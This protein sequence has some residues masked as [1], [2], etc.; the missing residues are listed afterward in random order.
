MSLEI[1]QLSVIIQIPEEGGEQ[2]KIKAMLYS[3]MSSPTKPTT[4]IFAP[5]ELNATP[6]GS[7]SCAATEKE[8]TNIA[9]DTSNGVESVYSLTSSPE[10]PTTNIFTPS[11]LNATPVDKS[12]CA[13][14]EKESTKVV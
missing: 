5:L 8:S 11:D 3:L 2:G 12:S 13:A 9:V 1:S 7:L 6:V 10:K 14:T 4:N